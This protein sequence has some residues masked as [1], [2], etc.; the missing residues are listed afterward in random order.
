[1]RDKNQGDVRRKDGATVGK[2]ERKGGRLCEETKTR[3]RDRDRNGH[4]RLR[5]GAKGRGVE[6]KGKGGAKGANKG[7][8]V[9]ASHMACNQEVYLTAMVVPRTPVAPR[10]QDTNQNQGELSPWQRPGG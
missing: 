8:G 4:S 1:M 3:D 6:G 5:E 2:E 10:T 9:R 7:G